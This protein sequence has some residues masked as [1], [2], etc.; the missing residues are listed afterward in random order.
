MPRKLGLSL[1]VGLAPIEKGTKEQVKHN[2]LDA[3]TVKASFQGFHLE[4]NSPDM[5]GRAS[6]SL[7]GRASTAMSDS[8]DNGFKLVLPHSSERSNR[9][10][11]RPLGGAGAGAGAGADQVG[12]GLAGQTN[13]EREG[14]MRALIDQYKLT[15]KELTEEDRKLFIETGHL[16]VDLKGVKPQKSDKPWVMK[17]YEGCCQSETGNDWCSPEKTAFGLSGSYFIKDVEGNIVGVFKPVDEEMGQIHGADKIIGYPH[18]R[19]AGSAAVGVQKG[20]GAIFEVLAYKLSDH[21]HNVNVPETVRVSLA[22]NKFSFKGGDQEACT[23]ADLTKVGSLQKFVSGT[24]GKKIEG[25]ARS[26]KPIEAITK[27]AQ[28][29]EMMAFDLAFYAT[30]RN[31]GNIIV[32]DQGNIHLIDHSVLLAE[33]H[34]SSMNC[35]WRNSEAASKPFSEDTKTQILSLDLEEIV[36]DIEKTFTEAGVSEVPDGYIESL[37]HSL[38]ILKAGVKLGFTA[39]EI[40]ALYDVLSSDSFDSGSVINDLEFEYNPSEMDIDDYYFKKL[41]ALKEKK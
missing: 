5:R 10:S 28:F 7:S 27:R 17:A 2:E 40:A 35:R 4:S 13:M 37:K 32:D 34:R 36:S 25:A 38:A 15:F 33:G 18:I 30:D 26:F 39:G 23:E 41:T 19:V 24:V 22:S 29:E 11:F 12:A 21:F 14:L 9:T 8:S 3:D 6:T 31:S 20:H 16:R 1:N